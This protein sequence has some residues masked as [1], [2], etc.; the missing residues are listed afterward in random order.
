MNGLLHRLAA[1]AS[2]TAVLV[3]SDARLPNARAGLPWNDNADAG[4]E[5]EAAVNEKAAA[6][7]EVTRSRAAPPV[8]K[9][10]PAERAT[11]AKP[12]SAADKPAALDVAGPQT[13]RAPNAPQALR[14]SVA[15]PAMQHVP[16][17]GRIDDSPSTDAASAQQPTTAAVQQAPA[18]PHQRAADHPDATPVAPMHRSPTPLM[19]SRPA[20]EATQPALRTNPQRDTW[21]QAASR[22]PA[23]EGQGAEVHVH[24]GRIE[25]TAL[26]PAQPA[27]R[28]PSPIPAPMTLD[29]YLARRRGSS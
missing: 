4:Q 19:P 8:A 6:Q 21:Q 16:M 15:Q 20:V 23:T 14:P 27:A 3:R 11:A 2:G 12:A 29:A 13:V 24:I 9:A 1:R 17:F 18:K 28:K 5:V 26:R 7:R 22:T 10:S 25:V